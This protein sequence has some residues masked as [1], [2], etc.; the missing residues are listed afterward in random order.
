MIH[1]LKIFPEFFKEVI[2]GK[3]T[4]EI[5][6]AD[7]PFAVGDLL[8]LNEFDPNIPGYTDNSCL[9]YVDYILSGDY[10]KDGYAVMSIKPCSVY[11]NNE[12]FNPNKLTRDYSVPYATRKGEDDGGEQQAKRRTV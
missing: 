6:K 7:R 5:R 1:E 2:S 9:V 10:C 3:K 12:P 11:M 8:A 4:F